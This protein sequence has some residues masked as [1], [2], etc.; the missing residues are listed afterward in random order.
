[1]VVDGCAGSGGAQWDQRSFDF[2]L[3]KARRW[4]VA[5]IIAKLNLCRA[6]SHYERKAAKYLAVPPFAYVFR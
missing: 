4:V 1:M 3:G 2:A 5:D 6:P